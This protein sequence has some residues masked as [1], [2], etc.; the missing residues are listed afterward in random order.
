[1]TKALPV[2]DASYVAWTRRE[3]EAVAKSIGLSED[4]RGRASLVATELATNLVR[5]GGGG[6]MLL[7]PLKTDTATGLELIAMD[8]GPGITNLADSLRDGHSTYGSAGTGLGAI[9]R[10]SDT[11]DIHCPPGQGTAV[12]AR[13]WPRRHPPPEAGSRIGWVSIPKRDELVCGD[14]LGVLHAG[15][16]V[17]AMVVD[18]LGHGVLANAAAEEARRLFC[19]QYHPSP[20][21]AVQKIHAGLRSTRGAAVAVVN[22]D[23]S[24]SKAVFCGIGNIAGIAAAGGN[25]RRFVSMNGIAGHTAGRIQEFIYP[26]DG[27][28]LVV[29]LHSDGI[30]ANWSLERSPGL[31]ARHPSLIAAVLLRDAGRGRDDATALVLKRAP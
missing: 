11:F 1:M 7:Q 13:I 16:T 5:H 30:S 28:G 29:I 6:E 4:D 3:V 25:V 21:V 27:P 31:A 12:L 10:Q 18:G 23:F 24:E 2:T 22:V 20:M 14:S 17:S 19:T 26:C 9:R 15:A 8:R